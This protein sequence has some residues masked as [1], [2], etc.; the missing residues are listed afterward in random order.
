MAVG[1]GDGVSTGVIG[2]IGEDGTP[3]VGVGVGAVSIGPVSENPAA[4]SPEIKN[5]LNAAVSKDLLN[6]SNLLGRKTAVS[7]DIAE[8]G[9]YCHHKEASQSLCQRVFL[10]FTVFLYPRNTN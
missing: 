3:G 4:I 10:G 6:I 7:C 9:F 5:M 1:V 8:P 2:G